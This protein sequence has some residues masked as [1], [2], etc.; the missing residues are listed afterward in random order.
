MKIGRKLFNVLFFFQLFACSS[1]GPNEKS[2]ELT[3][4]DLTDTLNLKF[5]TGEQMAEAQ[6]PSPVVSSIS[7]NLD[8]VGKE[9]NLSKV[10]VTD[11]AQML[12]NFLRSGNIPTA[13]CKDDNDAQTEKICSLMDSIHDENPAGWVSRDTSKGRKVALKPA[14]FNAQQKIGFGR[15]MRSI[16]RDPAPR[17]LAWVPKLLATRGCPRN[18]SAAAIRKIENSLPSESGQE[19]MEKLYT[20]ASECLK[21]E[22]EGYELTHLRQALLR[23]YWGNPKGAKE[24]ILK[25][26]VAKDSSEK[27][28]VL[29][30]AGRLETDP[31]QRSRHWKQLVESYPLS[32]HALE[33]FTHDRVDPYE[34]V[35]RRPLISLERRIP[36]KEEVDQA[37]RWLEAMYIRGHVEGA[38]RLTRFITRFYKA[39]MNPQV[40]LYI[41]S[42]KSAKGSALNTIT[43]LTRQVNENPVILNA[44]TLRMLFPRPYIET[45]SRASPRTDVNLILSVARQESGFHPTARSPANARGLLQLL[46]STARL[47]N[48]KRNNNLYDEELNAQ[49]GVKYLSQMIDKFDGAVELALAGYNA[50]PG[51]IPEWKNRFQP[52]ETL[53]F[54]DLI[55]FKETRNYVSNILRNNYW[56]ARLYQSPESASSREPAS[57]VQMSHYVANTVKTHKEYQGQMQG[58]VLDE[59]FEKSFT[60][61]APEV[62]DVDR[63]PDASES[64]A[65]TPPEGLESNGPSPPGVEIPYGGDYPTPEI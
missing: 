55:P 20:H 60:A 16:H 53:L 39:D 7:I 18:L 24:A 40:L 6:T 48:G 42:L 49:L 21:P 37:I 54:M 15:L 63:S 26:V 58:K 46:P 10:Q 9:L 64:T 14:Q 33:I 44:Q 1:K 34:L 8:Q 47:L 25:A 61:S 27:S 3:A 11:Q 36:Q 23:H 2:G 62:L 17:V 56:Y 31:K 12:A 65:E 59:F 5:D 29:Y 19:A 45:F 50:G 28:R 22:D 38:Q 52:E 35:M 51:R 32:F 13:F 43:F 4:S 41:S 57:N 30:W